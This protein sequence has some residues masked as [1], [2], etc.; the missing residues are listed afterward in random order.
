MIDIEY[1][2]Y[3]L[4]TSPLLSL[5]YF[6]KKFYRLY[7][8]NNLTDNIIINGSFLYNETNELYKSKSNN[9]SYYKNIDKLYIH[10]K[11]NNFYINIEKLLIEDFNEDI[12]NFVYQSD[13]KIK[14]NIKYR[15][16]AIM[17]STPIIINISFDKNLL[18]NRV[19]LSCINN[20]GYGG[21]LYSFLYNR[22]KDIKLN[23][24]EN[25]EL[26]TDIDLDIIECIH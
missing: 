3:K 26:I 22:I 11:D 16:F 2:I 23:N 9:K 13:I 6:P 12:H 10:T 24:L 19:S 17:L 25:I 15:D 5:N 7:Q 4:S 14:K 20:N 1:D 8:Y 18:S 21:S